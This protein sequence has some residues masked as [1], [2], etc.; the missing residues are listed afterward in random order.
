LKK[1]KV[2]IAGEQALIREGLSKIL[3]SQETIEFIGEAENSGQALVLAI[4][5][6]PD[7][8]LIDIDMHGRKN[9]EAA[10]MIKSRMPEVGIIV[11]TIDDQEDY[12]FELIK[13]GVSAYVLKDISPGFLVQ[14]ILG[15]ARG[16]SF[17]HS[18]M[19]SKMFSEFNRLTSF[20]KYS[21]NPHG[22]TKREFD[23]LRLVARGD[24]NR[25]IAQKLFISEKTVKNHLTNI[26]QKL[27]V[28]DRT[29]AAIHAVK[30]KMV[31]L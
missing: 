8:V 20:P 10:R 29:Q 9:I 2:L 11:L 14:T 12:L 28:D 22:L 23:V 25:S 3:N 21:N 30:N 18:V 26:F 16:E 31:D 13:A 17:I 4:K 6:K 5:L 7:V 19:T 27:G 15:V 24:S 1:V